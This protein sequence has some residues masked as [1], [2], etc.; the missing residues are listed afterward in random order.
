M[1]I[2]RSLAP[3]ALL[4]PSFA[5]VVGLLLGG[6]SAPGQSATEIGSPDDSSVAEFF[7][8]SVTWTDCGT[9]TQCASI[10][11]P[12]D[13]DHPGD[14]S[15]TLA[16]ARLPAPAATR[17]GSVLM[18]PGGPGA[19]GVDFV[20]G[21]GEFLA[22][23]RLRDNFD[24]V[25]WDPRGVGGSTR[26]TCLPDAEK[27]VFLYRTWNARYG[28]DA[29]VAELAE[30]E[31]A[32]VAACEANT[33]PLLEF[34]DS[35][36]TAHDMELIRVLLG[37]DTLNYLGYSYGTQFGAQ[38]AALFPKRVGRFVL[39]GATDPALGG[40]EWITAQMTGFDSAMTSFIADCVVTADCPL[41]S[42]TSRA[43][44]NLQALIQDLD[45]RELPAADGRVLDAATLG[46]GIAQ[47]LYSESYWPDLRAMF[48]DVASGNALSAFALADAYNGRSA[49]GFDNNSFEVYTATLCLDSDFASDTGSTVAGIRGVGQAAPLVGAIISY[50]DYAHLDVSCSLWP[51]PPTTP[52]AN[53]SATGAAPIMVVGTTNDPATPYSGAQALASALASGF[54]VTRTGE[55]H[56]AYAGGNACID[57]TVDDYFVEGT[58]PPADPQC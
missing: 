8:Q 18:N 3:R 29:W 4:A 32:F 50:D 9:A 47:A 44:T 24:I 5:A 6:C 15:M 16:V 56:T 49:G 45:A 25:S 22:T 33:G 52:V 34:V 28:T 40:R 20:V 54:L 11:A 19:S 2:S 38:Y 31:K 48:A 43:A 10:T 12:I 13:W 58:V 14:G 51:Y 1:G 36:S 42:S 46:T 23:E 17:Q 55:G 53:P 39:D 27:D 41:G 37:E 21:S 57:T 30:A 7:E 35:Q 26:V